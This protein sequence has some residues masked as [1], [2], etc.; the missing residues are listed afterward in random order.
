[1][2]AIAPTQLFSYPCM[3]TAIVLPSVVTVEV[4]RMVV[5]TVAATTAATVAAI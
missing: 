1:M 4:V 3:E 5:A 2:I